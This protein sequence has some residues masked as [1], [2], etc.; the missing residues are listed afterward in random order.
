M[1][2][3]Y[4]RKI[5]LVIVMLIMCLPQGAYAQLKDFFQSLKGMNNNDIKVIED[6]ETMSAK[7]SHKLP[8]FDLDINEATKTLVDPFKSQLP[9]KSEP[10]PEQKQ[11]IERQ[12]D[13]TPK[14][15]EVPVPSVH[16][17][18]LVWNT[19]RPQ[20]IIDNDVFEIG[21]M[22]G[23]WTIINISREGI[24]IESETKTQHILKP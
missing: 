17:A 15:E 8:L 13:L 10:S 3:C 12:V 9:E 5:F 7:F 18:G 6:A 24:T 4:L 19:Q 1:N 22:I 11:E 2:N 23:G 20:A 21:D 16:I 14:L